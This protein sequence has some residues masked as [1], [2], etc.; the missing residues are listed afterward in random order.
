MVRMKALQD[1]CEVK[2]GV[3]RRYRKR[4]E[5]KTKEQDQYK[6]VV[7]ILNVELMEKTATLEQETIAVQSWPRPIL[8]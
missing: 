1:R 7:R 8:I 3:I 2:E 6:E 5:Y 4:Q